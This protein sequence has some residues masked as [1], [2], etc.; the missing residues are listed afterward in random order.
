MQRRRQG[1][2]ARR[3]EVVV[4]E[5]GRVSQTYTCARVDRWVGGWKAEQEGGYWRAGVCVG[6]GGDTRGRGP[7][8]R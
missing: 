2:A 7:V 1:G 3:P 8:G 4:T 5:G 6:L